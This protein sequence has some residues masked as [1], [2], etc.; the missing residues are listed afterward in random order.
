VFAL[1]YAGQT[2]PAELPPVELNGFPVRYGDD[3]AVMYEDQTFQVLV[4]KGADGLVEPFSKRFQDTEMAVRTSFTLSEC[5]FELAKKHREMD[6]ES[7]ARREIGQARKLLAET[8]AVHHDED[9]KAHAEY[10]L[11]NLA[12]EFADL[13]KNEESKLPMYQ[14]AL[15]R[16][17]RIPL[18]YPKSEFAP[19]SQFKLALVYEKMGEFENAIEEYIKLAYKYPDDELIP[20]TMMR[21][22]GYFQKRGLAFKKQADE[23]RELKDEKSLSE[24]LRLDGLSYPEFLNAAMV[25]GKLQERF[26]DDKLAG[27]AALAAAQNFMRASQYEPAI[28]AFQRVIDN[29]MYDGPEIRAQAMY[30]CGLSYERSAGLM[31]ESNW[32]GRGISINAAY[33][34][35]RRVTF[36]FPDGLWAKYARGRL[37]DPA[38]EKIVAAE[39]KEREMMINAIKEEMKKR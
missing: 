3:V 1:S 38:F 11:G 19:K 4:N 31:A 37:A 22:G 34:L 6:Q 39:Q 30:W 10:L 32:K 33:K 26:P 16:F 28:A 21:L 35:Y 17:T 5:Y 15:A 36:D 18:D 14:D 23:I 9:L 13:A 25:Y 2:T 29:E 20:A 12:Q 24:V 27:L 7:L 8:L